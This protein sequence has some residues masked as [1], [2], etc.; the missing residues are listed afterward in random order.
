MAKTLKQAV[1]QYD[2]NGLPQRMICQ[3]VDTVTGE[4][5]QTIIN[6]DEMGNPDKQIFDN[7]KTMVEQ[8]ILD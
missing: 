5:Q 2:V 6:R 7:F 8:H 4:E 1:V 3:Y